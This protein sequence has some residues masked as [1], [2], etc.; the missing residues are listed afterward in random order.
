[1][2]ATRLLALALLLGAAP[3]SLHAQAQ[4]APA[5]AAPA[6]AAPAQAQPAPAQGQP[7]QK[8]TDLK[9]AA[10][11]PAAQAPAQRQAAPAANAPA[12]QAPATQTPAAQAPA[13]QA[14]AAQAPA[15]QAPAAQGSRPSAGAATTGVDP[16][17]LDLARKLIDMTG[18]TVLGE[19]M[20]ST[21]VQQIAQT[22][23]IANPTKGPEV[24]SFVSDFFLPQ[25]REDMPAFMEE[26]AKLYAQRFGAADLQRIIA[27]YQSDVGKKML[28]ETPQI[29][30]QVVGMGV[31]WGDRISR[32][33][34][35]EFAK[36]A[37]ARG[38]KVPG[39]G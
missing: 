32:R 27:F 1:M 38:L 12:A 30:Q 13:A 3:A 34:Q 15:A 14:P 18:A 25:L 24:E 5:Q 35:E 21:T 23:K 33:S 6:Q 19:Q 11:A 8:P 26:V 20:A 9:P 29:M 31:S 22:M 7:A 10:Q 39:Q 36:A 28:R 37:T 4:P 2:R 16:R 17:A